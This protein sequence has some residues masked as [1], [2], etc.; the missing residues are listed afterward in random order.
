MPGLL[1]DWA[2]KAAGCAVACFTLQ[3]SAADREPKSVLLSTSLFSHAET[4]MYREPFPELGKRLKFSDWQTYHVFQSPI[5]DACTLTWLRPHLPSISS[6]CADG[7]FENMAFVCVYQR[8]SF[9]ATR[10]ERMRRRRCATPG[11]F[12]P[13]AEWR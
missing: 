11:I 9:T 4:V 1:S 13:V 6:L 10:P 5:S 7:L 12:R 2:L 3:Q 8:P